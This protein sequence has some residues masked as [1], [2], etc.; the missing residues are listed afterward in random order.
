MNNT[1]ETQ[2]QVKNGNGVQVA[3]NVA[4]VE[5]NGR[6]WTYK[7]GNTF[8]DF[9]KGNPGMDIGDCDAVYSDIKQEAMNAFS[10]VK[11]SKILQVTFTAKFNKKDMDFRLH[12][13][14]KAELD[15]KPSKELVA[16]AIEKAEK[17][18]QDQL[19]L[20]RKVQ[21]ERGF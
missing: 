8:Q 17:K 2:E 21:R 15:E 16:K 6:Q 20:M 4:T 13:T 18:M 7:A 1:I 19:I 11:A 10:A 14:V 12:R 9:V 3:G 5:H